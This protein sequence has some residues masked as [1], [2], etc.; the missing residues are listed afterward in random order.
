MRT[1]SVSILWILLG[2]GIIAVIALALIKTRKD[3]ESPPQPNITSEAAQ[4]ETEKTYYQGGLD[5]SVKDEILKEEFPYFGNLD[6]PVALTI[7]SQGGQTSTDLFGPERP[8]SFI[9]QRYIKPGIFTVVYRPIR[10]DPPYNWPTENQIGLLCAYEQNKFWNYLDSIELKVNKAAEIAQN[11][12]LDMASFNTCQTSGKKETLIR[13]SLA[14]AE[15]QIQ[16]VGAPTFTVN[17]QQMD[18]GTVGERRKEEQFEELFR[19]L[20]TMLA[21]NDGV[22]WNVFS[23]NDFSV[24]YP[25]DWEIVWSTENYVAFDR[26]DRRG[27]YPII[28][29][30]YRRHDVE[31]VSVKTMAFNEDQT[32]QDWLTKKI[33][34]GEFVKKLNTIK[35]GN[36]VWDLY[37]ARSPEG[38]VMSYV[39]KAENKAFII[40]I[41]KESNNT[42]FLNQMIESFGAM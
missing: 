40:S 28:Q 36:Y 27:T 7:F 2:I 30:I 35:L 37:E 16:P 11:I 12:G 19:Q 20:E 38:E 23:D 6:A 29:P 31:A 21:Q 26:K 33:E 32:Y 24:H 41:G 18:L 34:F 42:E 3:A 22:K 17:G 8:W 9:E 5:Q 25:V 10:I 13:R 1:G 4:T 14:L 39:T 15:S